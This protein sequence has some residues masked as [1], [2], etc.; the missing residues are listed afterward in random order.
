MTNPKR[1]S[2]TRWLVTVIVASMALVLAAC[3][4]DGAVSDDDSSA[5]TEETT[6]TT[7]PTPIP[8][9]W[10]RVLITLNVEVTDTG[11]EPASI[12]IPAGRG[13]QLLMRNH[14]TTEHHLRV[15]GA[16][17]ARLLWV[18]RP[19][20]GIE[21]G[22]TEEDHS[23]HH[24]IGYIDWRGT[25]DSGIAITGDEIHGWSRP[26]E[27]EIMRFIISEPGTYQIEDVLFPELT[28]ELTVFE[29]P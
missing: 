9:D 13:I 1:R 22:V 21:D 23:K 25:S 11:F 2:S 4:G 6:A 14:G 5:E 24:L 27:M 16:E 26:T 19:D 10:D 29:Q 7:E 20:T 12:S 8:Q 3:G 17:P 18:A 28:G 15:V